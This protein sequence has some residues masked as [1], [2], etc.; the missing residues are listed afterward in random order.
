MRAVPAPR[1]G[2]R[3][4]GQVEF[5]PLFRTDLLDPSC[6]RGARKSGTDR[7]RADRAGKRVGVPPG[8]HYERSWSHQRSTCSSIDSR[9]RELSMRTRGSDSSSKDFT[10]M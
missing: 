10:S 6:C 8:T 2:E 9:D 3:A 5:R 1:T 7:V 4:G